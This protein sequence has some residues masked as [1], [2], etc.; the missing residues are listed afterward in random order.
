MKIDNSYYAP[1]NMVYKTK[2]GRAILNRIGGIIRGTKMSSGYWRY[3]IEG[4][5]YYIKIWGKRPASYDII[6][7]ELYDRLM[8]YDIDERLRYIRE[9]YRPAK[10]KIIP[11]LELMR[12]TMRE[13]N[14]IKELTSMNDYNLHKHKL[15]KN[16]SYWF[17]RPKFPYI[18]YRN[19][20][21]VIIFLKILRNLHNLGYIIYD[22]V[23][24]I[25]DPMFNIKISPDGK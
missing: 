17:Y 18:H 13:I 24:H 10:T 7:I 16:R 9:L 4:K 14:S 11:I 8:R 25:G 22:N 19:T 2:N 21:S 5:D 6:P 23:W 15:M 20:V 1:V 3:R 12:Y